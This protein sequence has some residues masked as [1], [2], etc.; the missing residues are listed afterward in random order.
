M[1]SIGDRGAGLFF[2]PHYDSRPTVL[3]GIASFETTQCVRHE[4]PVVYTSIPRYL[5][6]IEGVINGTI[7]VRDLCISVHFERLCCSPP[8]SQNPAEMEEETETEMYVTLLF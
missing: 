3:Y 2:V 4:F 1:M 8:H 7:T 5:G 6:W